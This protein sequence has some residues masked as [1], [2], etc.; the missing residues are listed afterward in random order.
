MT[1]NKIKRLY[2]RKFMVNAVILT[3][4]GNFA[5]GLYSSVKMVAGD[6]ENIR[7]CEFESGKNYENLD[8]DLI[9]AYKD[10]DNYDNILILCDIA[11]GTPFNRAVVSLGSNENVKFVGGV[12]FEILYQALTSTKKDMASYIEDVMD[13]GQK[14]IFLYK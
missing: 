12:N 1:Y 11:G 4:H 10:L 9:S 6:F 8:E 7:L 2:R 3:G 14:S 5:S 13:H